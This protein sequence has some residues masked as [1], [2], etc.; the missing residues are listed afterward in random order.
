MSITRRS[1]NLDFVRD[2]KGSGLLDPLFTFTRASTATRINASG[3]LETVA[4]NTPRFDFDPVTLEC[5]GLLIEEGRTNLLVRS[6]EFDSTW[7]TIGAAVTPNSTVS[8][9]GATSGDSIAFT[10]AAQVFQY[11][12][13]ST[14]TQYTFSVWLRMATGTGVARLKWY[15]ASTVTDVYSADLALTSAWQR[16]SISFTTGAS[17]TSFNVAVANG[18]DSAGRTI[19]AWGA[20]LEQGSFATSYIPTTSAAVARAGETLAI[21]TVDPWYAVTEGTWLIEASIPSATGTRRTLLHAANATDSYSPLISAETSDGI[22]GLAI[23]SGVYVFDQVQGAVAATTKAALIYKS[24]A[25]RYSVDG[26]TLTGS[27]PS[28]PIKP[29]QV[30]IGCR[31]TPN[32]EHANGHIRRFTYLPFAVDDLTL[33]QMTV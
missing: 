13:V 22:R 29:T 12:A 25:Y 5:K 20:Q 10:G 6:S 2:G 27:T 9:D 17:V 4:A 18:V 30:G 15:D 24:G 32:E 26:I 19:V 14:S 28:I 23:V 7:S 11:L 21:L 3:L 1:L 8:P 16:F 33:K 31:Y